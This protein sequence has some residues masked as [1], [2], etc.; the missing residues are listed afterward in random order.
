MRTCSVTG[1]FLPIA[2]PKDRFM[3]R[4]E[5]DPNSGCWL[6]TGALDIGGY[7][8]IGGAGL[9]NLKVHRLSYEAN[10]GP[11]PPGLFVLHKCDVRCCCNPNHLFVGTKQD[12]A[13]DAV[14]KG[15]WVDNVGEK[16][17]M[18]KLSNDSVRL[19]RDALKTDE[20]Q[21]SIARRFGVHQT[22]ICDIKRGKRRAKN[23]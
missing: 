16:H 2:P 15:W 14:R 1:R 5:A 18:S 8:L 20:T 6:W 21:K 12:N 9:S 11:I 13:I 22:T 10:V 17:G 19:I 3:E 23:V 7:G 4:V